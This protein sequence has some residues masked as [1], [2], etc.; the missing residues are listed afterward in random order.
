MARLLQCALCRLYRSDTRVVELK[1][2]PTRVCAG[3][4]PKK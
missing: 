4:K 1:G 2:I 3:C